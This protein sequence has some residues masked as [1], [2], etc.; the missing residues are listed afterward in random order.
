MENHYIL[1]LERRR[2]KLKKIFISILFGITLSLFFTGSVKAS[3]VYYK[4]KLG[5]EF[6][7]DEYNFYS[8]M[9]FEGVQENVN[10]EDLD[11]VREYNLVGQTIEKVT[12]PNLESGLKGSQNYENGR[13]LTIGKTC[14]GTCLYTLTATWNTIPG[15]N[16]YD[17]I[18]IRMSSAATITGYGSMYLSATGYSTY[19]TTPHKTE[20]NG[21]GY[22]V[23]V[24]PLSSV[25]VSTSCYTT[26][27]G[28]AYGSYQH[29]TSSVTFNT[30]NLYHINYTGYGGVHDFYGAA[31]GKY[32]GAN[33][34]NI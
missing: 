23:A 20:G 32:D 31:A 6:T 3:N 13:T 22:S 17:V 27:G 4:N 26:T 5:V 7:K 34:V 11:K 19:A 30:S 29:A 10:Q 28:T 24:P 8:E 14:S 16:S 2:L 1:N 9:Y 25:V 33:G 21:F 12:L 18:G 15:T